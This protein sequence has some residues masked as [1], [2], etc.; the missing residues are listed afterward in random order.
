M[1]LILLALLVPPAA[2]QTIATKSPDLVAEPVVSQAKYCRESSGDISLRLSF[3]VHFKNTTQSAVVLPLFTRLSR[4]ELFSDEAA[5][6]QGRNDADVRYRT[7][8]V[9]DAQKLDQAGPDPKLFRIL[10]AGETA[11]M[12]TSLFVAVLPARTAKSPLLG[13]DFYLKLYM[14]PWPTKR[15]AGER[16]A[17]V[18]QQYGNLVLTDIPSLPFKFHVEHQPNS[19][20]CPIRVD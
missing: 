10:N 9:L 2:G 12:Y 15:S 6:I 14:N 8:D 17:R 1:W 16:L 19:E 18:W 20:V 4:Y 3:I 5:L 13:R 11:S 7:E